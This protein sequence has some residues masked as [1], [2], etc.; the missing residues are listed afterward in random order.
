MTKTYW[1]NYGFDVY[2]PRNTTW[3]DVAGI[4]IFAG[5]TPQ[6]KWKAIYIGQAKSFQGRIPNHEN[7]AAAVRLGASHIHAMVVSLAANRDT[8]EAALIETYQ[9]ALNVQLK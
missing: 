9:P 8:I 7:W 2:D 3:N 4:Y 1:L 6:Y 5:I